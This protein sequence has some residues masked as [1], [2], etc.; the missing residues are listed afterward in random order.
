MMFNRNFNIK[1][2]KSKF[3]HKKIG[4]LQTNF[5]IFAGNRVRSALMDTSFNI[6][7]INAH[8][9]FNW[10]QKLIIYDSPVQQ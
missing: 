10:Y 7:K 3:F 2:Q 9:V 4:R 1:F 5:A 8:E 6:Q